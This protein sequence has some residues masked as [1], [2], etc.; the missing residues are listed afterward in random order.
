[1]QQKCGTEEAKLQKDEQ[2]K[3][4]EK[5]TENGESGAGGNDGEADTGTGGNDGE[6][7]WGGVNDGDWDKGEGGKMEKGTLGGGY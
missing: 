1:M 2:Q 6:W 4:R 7:E 5:A 3:G